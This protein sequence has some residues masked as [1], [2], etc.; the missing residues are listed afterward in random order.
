MYFEAIVYL[1]YKIVS[2]KKKKKE[3]WATVFEPLNLA[4]LHLS[5]L[6]IYLAGSNSIIL[7]YGFYFSFFL[8]AAFS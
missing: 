7:F 5:W 4:Q 1:D 3:T 8:I 2:L 6:L